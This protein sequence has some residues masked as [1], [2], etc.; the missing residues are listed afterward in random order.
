MLEGVAAPIWIFGYGEE[1][2]DE[3][4]TYLEIMSSKWDTS[5]KGPKSLVVVGG[6]LKETEAVFFCMAAGDGAHRCPLGLLWG[7][8]RRQ[9]TGLL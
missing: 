9:V 6:W 2:I 8:W 1:S 5:K 7:Q 4:Q 3:R